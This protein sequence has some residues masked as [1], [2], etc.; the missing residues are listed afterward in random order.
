M[1]LPSIF[2]S[3]TN[4]V[5]E[6][7]ALALSI[8]RSTPAMS[9]ALSRLSTGTVCSTSGSSWVR[10]EPT[11]RV[12]ESALANCGCRRSS[13]TRVSNRPSNSASVISGRASTW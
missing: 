10:S 11:R 3:T 7:A 4:A 1:E 2:S 5:P 12:G 6:S 13:S 9:Y 8:Q